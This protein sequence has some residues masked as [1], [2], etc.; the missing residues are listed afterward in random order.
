MH[1]MLAAGRL[2]TN[3]ENHRAQLIGTLRLLLLLEKVLLRKACAYT[4][5]RGAC[6]AAN[7]PITS[8]AQY[9]L[10]T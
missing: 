6:L 3:S 4:P 10:Q 9:V 2:V 8:S 5:L 7:P 1:W